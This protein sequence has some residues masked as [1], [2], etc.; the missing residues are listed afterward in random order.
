M[1][2]KKIIVS[3]YVGISVS[4]YATAYTVKPATKVDINKYNTVINSVKSDLGYNQGIE[5][6]NEKRNVILKK[7]S[8][9]DKLKDNIIVSKLLDAYD[10]W[11]GTKYLW[12]GTTK[13]GVDCSA[14]TRALY[15][16]AF[17]YSL[18]RISVEQVKKGKRVSY[19]NLKPGDLLYFRPL[20]RFNHVGIY[21][22]NNK[23]INS[24]S[25]KG[26]TIG[27]LK[28]SYWKKYFKYGVRLNDFADN[29]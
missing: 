18:P 5:L 22:G 17:D 11:K 24:S 19:N 3:F 6:L 1:N 16:E 13:K 28:S 15:K 8:V 26:V 25:T 2:L 14:L 7:A 23:F 21:I 4:V 27:D 9:Y 29:L 10:S 12:G 20:N